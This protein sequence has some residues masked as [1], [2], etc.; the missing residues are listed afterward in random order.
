M[1]SAAARPARSPRQSL[2][3]SADRRGE[4]PDFVSQP[5][6]LGVPLSEQ[7]GYRPQ[8]V[9]GS[10]LLIAEQA[11]GEC[12]HDNV[13]RCLQPHRA[14]RQVTREQANFTA[15]PHGDGYHATEDHGG[16]EEQY[17]GHKQNR[18]MSRPVLTPAPS[19][20][21][22]TGPALMAVATS[23]DTASAAVAA[24]AD[25]IDFTDAPAPDIAAFLTV[26]PG[27]PFCAAGDDRAAL[28]RHAAAARSGGAR[29]ICRDLAAARTSG[30]PAHQLIVHTVPDGIGG[31][32][33]AGYAA[34]ID[35]DQC[36]LTG[37]VAVAALSSWLGAT[38]IRT[39]HPL[40]VRRALDMT[41]TIAGSRPPARTVR[42]LA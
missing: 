2:L 19:K 23:L 34:L 6:N 27:V 38:L 10:L 36:G 24:G 41:A 5:G 31:V 25:I 17:E 35:A 15:V 26:S 1:G 14:F 9:A 33:R 8:R 40:P 12:Q 37:C 29:L 7:A 32:T 42:G 11:G 18:A 3:I 21:P 16:G 22:Q 39:R 28:T 13:E 30:L 4:L 20:G